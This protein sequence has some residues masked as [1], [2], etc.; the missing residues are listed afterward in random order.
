MIKSPYDIVIESDIYGEEFFTTE[1]FLTDKDETRFIK[2][3]ER[4]IRTSPEYKRWIHFVHG[5]LGTNY[6]CYL[7]GVSSNECNIELHHHPISLY[8]YV[9]IIL[10]NAESFTSYSIA[11][12]VMSLHFENKVGFIPLSKTSHELYHNN[13]LKIPIELVEGNWERILVEYTVPDEIK[14][15]IEACKTVSLDNVPEEWSVKER[16]YDVKT[17][18]DVKEE[19][20]NK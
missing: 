8:Q 11:E 17:N 2:H 15:K 3:V 19:G 7:T 18:K 20:E 13:Y 4:L 10:N 14:S 9:Q 5:A 6:I 12:K 16:Q 1:E